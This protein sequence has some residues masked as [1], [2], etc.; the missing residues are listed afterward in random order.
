MYLEFNLIFSLIYQP[1]LPTLRLY[2]LFYFILLFNQLL[3][4]KKMKELKLIFLMLMISLV[5]ACT[6]GT[7]EDNNDP[8][9]KL[10]DIT[11]IAAINNKMAWDLFEAE[12]AAKPGK[13][14]LISPFSIQTALSMANN[15]AGGNTLKEMLK[16]MYCTGCDVPSVNQKLKGLTTYLTKQSG[17]PTLSIANGYFYDKSRISLKEGFVN[18]LQT[19][20]SCTFKDENFNAEKQSL[21]NINGWVKSQT[22]DKIDKI[23]EK[24]TPLDVAFLINA[25]HFKADWSQGFNTASTYKHDFKKADGSVVKQD[26]V[27]DDRSVPHATTSGFMIADLPFKD[28][29]YSM[30]LI[31]HLDVGPTQKFT[32]SKYTELLGALKYQRALLSFPKIKMSYQTDLIPTLKSLGMKEAFNDQLADFKNMGT[33]AK[34][35]F[36]NQVIHKAVLEADEKGAEGAAVTA[37]GFG[38]TSVP[39][40]IRFDKPFYLIIRNIKTNT[41]MFIGY[42]GE[43][44]AS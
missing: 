34:N 41:I 25:L 6:E 30:S 5:V 40:P 3:K 31:S 10:E 28:S 21:D 19:D 36:I 43:N 20:Y 37:I 24:I 22:K 18:T 39:Q 44:P 7:K 12:T 38:I 17:H 42:V 35:I 33:A 16:L 11:S 2:Y 15:G 14:V 4:N 32:L 1:I 9:V 27:S 29:T 8:P 13:N 26:F 23:L